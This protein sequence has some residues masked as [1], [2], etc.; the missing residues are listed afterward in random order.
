MKTTISVHHNP[1]IL[2]RKRRTATTFPIPSSFVFVDSICVKTQVLWVSRA[3]AT[4]I[5]VPYIG[6]SNTFKH[7]RIRRTFHY[8]ECFW[9][10]GERTR[11]RTKTT[12]QKGQLAKEWGGSVRS[13]QTRFLPLHCQNKCTGY[14]PWYTSRETRLAGERRH[15]QKTCSLRET[16]LQ[17]VCDLQWK[18]SAITTDSPIRK[19]NRVVEIVASDELHIPIRIHLRFRACKVTRS[20]REMQSD[21]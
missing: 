14:Q 13:L 9:T 8:C 3:S 10:V 18:E 7:R 6:K 15:R 5:Q 12:C 17:T 20:V 4:L 21:N 11:K 2:F 1:I 19:M 16:P